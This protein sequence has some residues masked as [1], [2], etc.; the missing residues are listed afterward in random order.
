VNRVDEMSLSALA[1]NRCMNMSDLRMIS[2]G[3]EI[4]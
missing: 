2:T 1:E 4:R 3:S